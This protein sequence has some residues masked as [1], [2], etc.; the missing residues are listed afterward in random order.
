MQAA[1]QTAQIPPHIYQTASTYQLGNPRTDYGIAARVANRR[2]ITGIVVFIIGIAMGIWGVGILASSSGSSS[3][4]GSLA[5]VLFIAALI[6]GGFGLIAWIRAIALKNSNL[7]IY[8]C[9]N[10]L[11][12]TIGNAAPQ[13]FPWNQVQ[14]VWRSVTRHY[15]NG[16]YTGTTFLYTI[17]R[18]DGYRIVL[19]NNIRGIESLGNVI[20]DRI[21]KLLLPQVIQAYT[22]GQTVSFGALSLNQQGLGNG[23]EILPWPQVEAVDVKN[24]F[25]SVKR[26]GAWLRW[27]RVAAADI[28]N[29]FVF[30]ALIDYVLKSYGKR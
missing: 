25:I 6:L 23:S 17:Q 22:N 14:A 24:G 9:D 1:P 30:L 20:S 2:I 15:R 5:I 19:N 16:I 11:I 4:N 28:P 10:G 7:H 29:L 12:Y 3:D 26:Q 13:P 18:N 27:S 21:T 8:V